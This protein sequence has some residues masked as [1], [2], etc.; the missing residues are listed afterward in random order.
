[1]ERACLLL[2][3][4]TLVGA[5][6]T[7]SG[8]DVAEA[9]SRQD[10][11]DRVALEEAAQGEL[12]RNQAENRGV[13]IQQAFRAEL[14]SNEPAQTHDSVFVFVAHKKSPAA[15]FGL[16]LLA[17]GAGQFYN[18]EVGKGVA[19]LGLTLAGSVMWQI[20]VIHEFDF[21]GENRGEALRTMGIATMF[22]SW[23]WSMIDAPVSASRI[24]RETATKC[25]HLFEFI[26]EKHLLGLELVP[27]PSARR[28]LN[29]KLMLHF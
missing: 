9:L 12:F 18:G 4:A 19:M 25:G 22:G 6:P 16:S 28:S 26:N 3:S 23:L 13:S 14:L 24:N 21:T 27:T 8:Q 11:I 1:M 15:A 29:A 2:L 7:V 10:K 5:T 20:G 17:P